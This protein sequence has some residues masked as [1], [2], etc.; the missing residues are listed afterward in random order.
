MHAII[1]YST[2]TG[3]TETVAEWIRDRLL[4]AGHEVHMEDA[5]NIYPDVLRD[6]DL[7]IL[8]CPTYWD[9]DVTDD[10]V[11][12]LDRMADL[13]LSDKKA[14]VFGLGDSDSYPDE[15]GRS[16]EIIEDNLLRSGVD[17][18]AD[19]LKIDGPPELQRDVIEN[20]ADNLGSVTEYSPLSDDH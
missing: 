10:F 17:L 11:P 2:L 16:V 20:W 13:D 7:I 9:G 15:F 5:A 14:A 6:Y 1:A 12:F 8:G 18:V 4:Q 19:S 3:N